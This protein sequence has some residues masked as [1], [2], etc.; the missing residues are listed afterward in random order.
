MMV[1]PIADMLTRLKNANR[2]MLPSVE[3]PA[4]KIKGEILNI[5]KR[6]AYIR[7]YVLRKRRSVPYFK[8]HLHYTEDGVRAFNSIKQ[9]SKSSRRVYVNHDELPIVARGMG[10]A[11][12]STSKGI[13][14]SLE[15]R[16]AGVGG[17]VIC[18]IW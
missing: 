18:H 11:I 14:T 7:N 5:M 9:I 12:V 2:R 15:A 1:D 3:L 17:E 6:E 8:V 4:S 13:L 16:R 10:I